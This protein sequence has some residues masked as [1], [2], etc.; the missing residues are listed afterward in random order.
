MSLCI[1]FKQFSRLLFQKIPDP[2]AVQYS[3]YCSKDIGLDTKLETRLTLF[4]YSI[5]M[6]DIRFNQL[7]AEHLL[8]WCVNFSCHIDTLRRCQRNLCWTRSVFIWS[9]Q[10]I[11]SIVP[12]NKGSVPRPCPLDTPGVSVRILSPVIWN[13]RWQVS[14]RIST[15]FQWGRCNFRNEHTRHE[16]VW[17]QTLGYAVLTELW[18]I[19]FIEIVFCRLVTNLLLLHSASLQTGYV[20]VKLCDHNDYW[21]CHHDQSGTRLSIAT[22]C[23]CY[24]SAWKSFLRLFQTADRQSKTQEYTACWLTW[25]ETINLHNLSTHQIAWS[26][27]AG[28]CFWVCS[29]MNFSMLRNLPS[30]PGP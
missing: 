12:S 30:S 16:N 6:T 5:I 14:N 19:F 4:P 22:S 2:I 25:I 8:N 11:R 17:Y 3:V 28:D 20:K 13:S 15:R 21:H 18:T 10:L 1:A 7:R 29:V 9:C 27:S 23:L 24:D 26:L